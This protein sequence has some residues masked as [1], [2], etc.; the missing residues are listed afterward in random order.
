MAEGSTAEEVTLWR[1]V[2]AA[3]Y[4]EK[5]VGDL[6]EEDAEVEGSVP[7]P[8]ALGRRLARLRPSPRKSG[9]G[10]LRVTIRARPL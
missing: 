2:M 8:L 6:E 10:S 1:S 7:G 9:S 5:R 3:L 4:T